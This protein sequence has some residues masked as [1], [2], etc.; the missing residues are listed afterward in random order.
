[1]W[2]ELKYKPYHNVTKSSKWNEY[3]LLLQLT[4]TVLIEKNLQQ[5]NAAIKDKTEIIQFKLATS[6]SVNVKHISITKNNEK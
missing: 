5:C 2:N 4:S 6:S 1:M 3:V